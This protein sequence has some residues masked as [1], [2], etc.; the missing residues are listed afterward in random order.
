MSQFNICICLNANFEQFCFNFIRSLVSIEDFLSQQI[1]ELAILI[2]IR[3]FFMKRI[4][5]L[6]QIYKKKLPTLSLYSNLKAD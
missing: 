4:I 6:M 1:E 5:L 2:A 3:I